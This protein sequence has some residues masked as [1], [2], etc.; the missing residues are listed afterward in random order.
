VPIK[1]CHALGNDFGN[2]NAMPFGNARFHAAPEARNS[3]NGGRWHIV[4]LKWAIARSAA[5]H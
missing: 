3:M 5:F 4:Q 1:P 2:G